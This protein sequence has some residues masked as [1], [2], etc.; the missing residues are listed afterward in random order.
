MLGAS[1]DY[2]VSSV[3]EELAT[4]TRELSASDQEVAAAL[5]ARVH[6]RLLLAQGCAL[7]DVSRLDRAD[8]L[9]ADA[10]GI[11]MQ[12]KWPYQYALTCVLMGQIEVALWESDHDPNRLQAVRA[13]V[14][15][16]SRRIPA[17]EDAVLAQTIKRLKR[18]VDE[19]LADED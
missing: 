5:T 10:A 9:A 7:D 16:A 15:Q 18:D 8:S 1:P 3:A 2:R 14:R 13:H 11:L 17:S 19:L 12:E 4:V 6:A